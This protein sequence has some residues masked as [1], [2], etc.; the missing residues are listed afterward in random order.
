MFVFKVTFFY[1][2][3]QTL[4]THFRYFNDISDMPPL[5]KLL[6]IFLGGGFGSCCRWMLDSLLLR[7]WKH[8]EWPLGI[9]TV[10]MLGCLL[11]GILAGLL[12]KEKMTHGYHSWMWPLLATGF[13]GGFTT[14]STYCL[15]IIQSGMQGQYLAGITYA[16]ASIILGVSLAAAGYAL[17]L[18]A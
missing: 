2:A 15:N 5:F 14:F 9:F 6:L 18:R 11:M 13:L 1:I 3:G 4:A 10:N 16:L 7:F 12:L 17:I 8:P